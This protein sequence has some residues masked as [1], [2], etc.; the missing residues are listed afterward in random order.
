MRPV[1]I[2]LH[3]DAPAKPAYGATC[4]G[5]GVCCAAQPCPVGM[6]VSRR[7]S[8]ACKALRW[9]EAQA[10]YRCGMVTTPSEV[11]PGLPARWAPMVSRWM[12]RWIAAAA[13]CDSTLETQPPG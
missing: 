8:G 4:N 13:G 5:C 7:L 9:E 10:R 2:L 11:L 6:L 12:R 3:P 1:V